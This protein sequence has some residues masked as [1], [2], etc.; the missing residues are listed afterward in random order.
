MKLAAHLWAELRRICFDGLI[1]LVS[2]S[3]LCPMPLRL[4]LWK[5]VGIDIA[6]S[7]QVHPSVYVRTSRLRVGLGSTINRFCII[8]NVAPVSIGRSCGIGINVRFIT[9]GHE[10]DD[11]AVR[12]GRGITKPIVVGDGVFIGTGASVMAGVDIGEGCVVAA[13]AVVVRNCEP[14]GLYGGV[15]ARRLRDL[16]V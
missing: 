9:T 11:P 16:P 8:E 6:F 14:H 13:G 10:T 2:G 1:N 5:L 3:V 4:L 7:N 12:A 15:P